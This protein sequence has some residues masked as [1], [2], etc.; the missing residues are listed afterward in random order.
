M[1]QH[2]AVARAKQR[3]ERPPDHR[4]ARVRAAQGDAH[5]PRALLVVPELEPGTH[6]FRARSRQVRAI[7]ADGNVRARQR[8]RGDGAE[9]EPFQELLASRPDADDVRSRDH[10]GLG[11]AGWVRGVLAAG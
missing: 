7:H 10:Q 1:Q 6:A 9:H 8:R 5:G 3:R 11:Q 2:D 4:V